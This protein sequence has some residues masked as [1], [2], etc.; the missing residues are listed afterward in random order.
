MKRYILTIL[1]CL[2]A[3]IAMSA[4]TDIDNVPNVHLTDRNRFVSNPDN[5]LSD[6]CVDSLDA[7]LSRTWKASSAEPVVIALS[8]IPEKYQLIDFAV[9]LGEKWGVGKADKD[10]GVII[11][12]VTDRRQ[13]TIAPGKGAEGVLPDIVCNR[14]IRDDAIPHFREGN[15]DGGVLAATSAVCRVLTDPRYAEELRSAQPNDSNASDDELDIIALM[16][17]FGAVA[18]AIMLILVIRSYIAN[19]HKEETVRYDS[20]NNLRPVAL[21]LS[22]LG[23]GLPLPAFLLCSFLMNRLRNHPRNCPNCTH[24]MKKLDEQTDNLYLTP[25]QDREERLDSVD[26]DVWLCPQCGEKDVIPYINRKSALQKCENC[27]SRTSRLVSNRTVI[28]PTT[29]RTGTGERIYVCE[30]CG[31]TRRVPY[32]IAKLAAPVVIIGPG[33]GGFGNGGGGGISG[34]S[35]GGG[36]FGGGGATGGW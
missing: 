35:F 3:L 9:A 31:H 23:L 8:D 14:I 36:S 26:Y 1:T 25:A 7:M 34:G 11:L 20:L 6:E 24:P 28:A 32:Q 22:F 29:S 13:I 21:F 15:Y 16:A 4:R 18:G 17:G 30:N 10:N 33:G 12:L 19:R 27:G 2:T 5:I